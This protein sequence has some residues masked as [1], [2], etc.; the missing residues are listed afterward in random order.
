MTRRE[1]IAQI[2]QQARDFVQDVH[3]LRAPRDIEDGD[4][5]FN[6]VDYMNMETLIADLDRILA[7]DEGERIE[8]AAKYNGFEVRFMCEDPDSHYMVDGPA[9]LIL[10]P[11]A[12]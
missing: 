11:E 12:G 7:L 2:V 8:G 1:Q 4:L 6:V 9:T 3:D 5:I 10:H